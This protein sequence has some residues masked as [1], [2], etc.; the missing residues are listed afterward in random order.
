MNSYFKPLRRKV[1]VLTMLLAY[2]FAM[3]WV[4]SLRQLDQFVIP[5]SDRYY[6]VLLN[7]GGKLEL[8]MYRNDSPKLGAKD[9]QSFMSRAT[10]YRWVPGQFHPIARSGQSGFR[11]L[12]Q[13]M[14]P[15]RRANALRIDWVVRYVPYWAIVLPLT[16]ISV[17][18]L[19]A[20]NLEVQYRGMRI[21]R[22]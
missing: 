10:Q 16:L 1:G 18:L 7:Y 12:V 4:R 19:L 5:T 20:K 3:A 22:V 21:S 6:Y 11:N 14:R 8:E 13:S 15:S 2:G 9:F 17:W